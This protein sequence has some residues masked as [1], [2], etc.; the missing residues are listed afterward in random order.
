MSAIKKII[1]RVYVG[2]D[3]GVTEAKKRGYSRICCCKD[4]PDGH[5]ALLGY[6][7]LGAPSG[8]E[9]L[10]AS[11][12]NVGAMN[13]IDNGDETMIADD[14]VFAALRFAK[15]EWDAGR[16]LFFHCNHGFER[17]PTMAMMFL[18]AIGELPQTLIGA[19][20]VYGTLYPDFSNKR[21]GLILKLKSL[22]G[23]LPNLFKR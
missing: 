21:E 17:G 1:D 19:K 10:F 16:T 18:R 22:W 4:G 23:A 7:T 8:P 5:R 9:Y 15:R 6:T 3:E 20:R 14:M 13:L 12:G 2:S 11:R